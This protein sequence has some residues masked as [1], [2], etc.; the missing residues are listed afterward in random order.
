MAKLLGRIRRQGYRVARD[1]GDLE[2]IE[3]SVET[4]SPAPALKREARKYAYRKTNTALRRVLRAV[5]L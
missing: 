4:G 2:A 5:G 1:L 3:K